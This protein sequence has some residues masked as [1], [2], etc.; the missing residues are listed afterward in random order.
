MKPY[1]NSLPYTTSSVARIS[2]TIEVT[3]HVV[4]YCVGSVELIQKFR[5]YLEEQCKLGNS[6]I[7]SY[8]QSLSHCLDFLRFKGLKANEIS[9]LI[10]TE[11]FFSRAKQCLRKKLRVEWNTVLSIEHLED[12]NC[13]A[14]LGDLQKVLPFHENRFQQVIN[15]A[16]G[17]AVIPHDLTF[18]T[19]FLVTVL[20]LK[21]KGSRPMTY[22]FLTI[23]MMRSAFNNGVI[24]Q[25]HF[26]TEE[27][28]GFDSLIF[29][30]YVLQKVRSY[31]DFVRPKLKPA[32][33]FLLICK[34][35]SQLANLGDVFGRMVYQAIGKYV[36]PTRYRQIIE[37]ASSNFLSIKDQSLISLDQKHT[38]NVA[39]V[40]YQKK[41]SREVAQ[42]AMNCMEKIDT[43]QPKRKQ[44]FSRNLWKRV[45]RR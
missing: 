9:T 16:K 45:R 6:G 31:I 43:G 24:D 19:S 23:E 17:N 13:W 34:S 32:C 2:T 27:K 7:I 4:E 28:Y 20:F 38:S 26:K 5:T 44:K 40:H 18:A 8:L 1:F 14:S 15:L 33:N 29:T 41:R 36:N 39:K 35:G 10:T 22:Q 42:K 3:R 21:V 12:I 30:D 37:T 25:T 11:V